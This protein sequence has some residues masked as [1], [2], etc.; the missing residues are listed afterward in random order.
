MPNYVTDTSDS[1]SFLS[2]SVAR[3]LP[4]SRLA[5]RQLSVSTIL[6]PRQAALHYPAPGSLRI[7]RIHTSPCRFQN[8]QPSAAAKPCPACSKP[9]PSFVP[10]CTKCWNIFSISPDVAHHELFGLP[11]EPNPFIVDLSALK[12]R[13][14]QAQAVCHPDMWAAKGL[15][16]ALCP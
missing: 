14:R 5:F 9:L 16:C 13:F 8:F 7:S 6:H 3:L 15:V 10:A 2:M 12:Q 11:Y 1:C 4:V